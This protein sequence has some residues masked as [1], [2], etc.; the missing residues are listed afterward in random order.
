MP[1]LLPYILSSTQTWR[2]RV[3]P[4]DA[5][6]AFQHGVVEIDIA[7]RAGGG[8]NYTRRG[9]LGRDVIDPEEF[10]KS[11][12]F[13]R[14]GDMNVQLGSGRR[15]APGGVGFARNLLEATEQYNPEYDFEQP[16]LKQLGSGTPTSGATACGLSTS[17]ADI[18]QATPPGAAC[19]RPAGNQMGAPAAVITRFPK[20]NILIR[21]LRLPFAI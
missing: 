21:I 9:A 5:E 2:E 4:A 17:S 19:T 11:V 7:L 15:M 8:I 12:T 10:D 16:G 1:R 18:H 13:H 14:Y 6:T 20:E 3:G